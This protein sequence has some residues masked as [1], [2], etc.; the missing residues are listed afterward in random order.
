MLYPMFLII[1]IGLENHYFYPASIHA[2]HEKTF[3]LV[4][5]TET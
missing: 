5:H 3:A 4:C 1:M 2:L